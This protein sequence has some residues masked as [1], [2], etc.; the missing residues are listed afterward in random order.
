MIDQKF[1]YV[2]SVTEHERGWG[3]RPDGYFLFES[4]E[5]FKEWRD[6]VYSSRV[7]KEVPYCYDTYDGIGYHPVNDTV[8]HD[9]TKQKDDNVWVNDYKK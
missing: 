9:F 5:K 7:S 6:R 1:L 4:E 8:Y 3:S 2:C